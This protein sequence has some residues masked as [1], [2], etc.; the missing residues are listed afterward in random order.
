MQYFQHSLTCCCFAL[1]ISQSAPTN[2]E[3]NAQEVSTRIGYTELRTNLPG[4][5]HANTSTS[6]AMVINLDGSG[7]RA[8]V[9][10]LAEPPDTWTQF[11]G[12]SPDGSLAIIGNGW[13]DP[14]NA[15]WEEEHK[16]FRM[17]PGKWRY[18]SWLINLAEDTL[19]NV[20]EVDRVSH[21]NAVSFTPDGTKLLMTSLVDG[22]SKPYTMNLD[23]TNK[24]D[25]SGG[26]N[27]FTYGFN[28][29]PDGKRICYHENYQVYLAN[30]DGSDKKHVVTGHPFN[31]APTWSPDGEWLLF[32]S[33]EHYDC[34]PHI[35]RA[36][37]TSLRKIADRAGY[38][39]VTEFL[40][41]P[42]FHGGSS[43]TPV[44]APDGKS[45]FYTAKVGSCVEL[46]QANLNGVNERLTTSQ[47]GTTH[48]HPKPSQ[49]GRLL[50]YGSKRDGARNI[51]VRNLANGAEQQITRL[52][53]G[54][55]A[56][57]PHWQPQPVANRKTNQYPAQ[58]RL[59]RIDTKVT[60]YATFQSHNQKVVANKY[61]YFTT[62]IR[63]RDKPYLAQT[64]RLSRST[65]Q[66][67]SFKT[68]FQQTDATNP[69][70]I[71]TDSAGN[72]YLIQVDFKSGDAFLYKFD[73]AKDFL[74][75]RVTTIPG[76]AA[77]KY[78][79]MLDEKSQRLFFFSHNN[80]FHRITLDG[81]VEHRTNLLKP[82]E[83]AILQ[84]PLLASASNGDLHAAWTTQ[85]HG[86][87]LYWDIHHM[88]T[89]N[90]G[91]SWT[92]FSGT[93]ITV[94]TAADNTGPS[95]QISSSDEF[96]FH[97]WL[98]SMALAGGK[99]HFAYMT[100]TVPP[101]ENYVRF[102]LASGKKDIHIQ[103]FEGATN[104]ILGLDG[105]FVTASAADH[106][107]FVGNDSGYLACLRSRDNGATWE[108]Y[109]R[110][111]IAFSLY[112]IGGFRKT[113]DGAIIGTFTNQKQ[114]KD[115]LDFLSDV[116]F[117]RIAAD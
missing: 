6:R 72:I 44:W 83:H 43:D 36:D 7:K 67:A 105:Y 65:D 103:E 101:R 16:T 40:D 34:H 110:T 25:V 19:T 116:Y 113:V 2:R 71:E 89:R 47:A 86:V 23:G 54:R 100:Q 64:W 88:L 21:Y 39:G 50:L 33:G 17:E 92:D 29:S 80:S 99:A 57:W 111:D 60:H 84:Y 78:A 11:A 70:V 38:S 12:W 63:D 41:V 104:R 117:F 31:F 73:A 18:D 108:D 98:S 53:K 95:D 112:S 51:Y 85:K 14:D 93:P 42:D 10:H 49:G 30:A 3:C 115:E 22:T 107:Y 96:E 27:G 94:P 90:H 68:I 5:R 106:I 58:I 9:S 74:D 13:Q 61:G 46:F 62:H 102:D 56:M 20:T 37:A 69:P 109:A 82:G 66:G 87:Y 75:P 35:V 91:E 4:G 24:T 81:T 32:V 48:Y 97:T 52:S 77:G 79:M 8:L 15:D 45:I 114:G 1:L 55:A 59:T 26:S 76:G 28:A